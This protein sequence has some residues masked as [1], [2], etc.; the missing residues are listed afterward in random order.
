MAA[1]LGDGG[2]ERHVD[3][4]GV[5]VEE[6][7]RR[8]QFQCG[9]PRVAERD[10]AVEIDLVQVG[11]LQFEHGL[12]RLVRQA[13]G[14]VPQFRGAVEVAEAGAEQI[15]SVLLEHLEDPEVAHHRDLDELGHAVADLVLGQG[16][17]EAEVQQ[18]LLRRVV[19][20]ETVLVLA[21][22]DGDLDGHGGVDQADERGGDA[23]VRRVAAVTGTGESGDVGG[24][25]AADDEDRLGAD[26]AEGVELTD[27]AL[28]GLEGLGRLRD[29]HLDDGEVD[30]VVLEVGANPVAVVLQHRLVDHHEDAAVGP[31][32]VRQFGV[33]G[34]EDAV[35]VHEV[36]LDLLV[37]LDVETAV[38]RGDLCL[39]VAHC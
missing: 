25:T 36:V 31:V 19:G 34:V 1:L 14:D 8:R 4:D 28:E 26:E 21:V 13:V 27:D 12:D 2:R 24:E 3:V 22:V 35:D 32:A 33:R 20:A 9:T 17:Q 10:D 11:C 37:S 18:H 39:H 30:P 23:D 16:G 5:T 6:R 15:G 7:R 38:A 29:V